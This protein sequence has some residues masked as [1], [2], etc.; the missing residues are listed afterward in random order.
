MGFDTELIFNEIELDG[1]SLIQLRDSAR[2][3]L[4]DKDCPWSYMLKYIYIVSSDDR[5]IDLQV[6]KAMW[7]E[8][9]KLNGTRPMPFTE[10]GETEP[11]EIGKME[12]C[13]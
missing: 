6:S 1:E 13:G 2:D 10:L 12:R 5:A 9:T 4:L 11:G 7:K 8:L 3:V